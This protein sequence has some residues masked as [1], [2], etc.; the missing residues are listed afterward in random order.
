MFVIDYIIVHELAHL[1][2]ANHS[3]EFWNIVRTHVP[4]TEKAR[5]WLS[6]NGQ[7]FEEEI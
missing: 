2:E 7:V 5:A 3:P 4:K 1:R 6:D